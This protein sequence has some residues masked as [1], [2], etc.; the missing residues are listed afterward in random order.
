[1]IYANYAGTS[2]PKPQAVVAAVEAAQLADPRGNADLYRGAHAEVARYFGCDHPERLL[3]APSCTSALAVAIG[4]L[5]WR[6]GD[7]VITSHLEHHAL[8][9]PIQKLAWDHGV[10]HEIAPYSPG[11]PIDLAW[12]A[13][14][15]KQGGVKLIAVTGASN[16]TGELLPV[17]ELSELAHSHGALLL[18]DAAQIAGVV[19]VDVQSLAI[20]LLVF[21][22]HKGMLA[23]HGVGGLWA[24]PHVEFICP[25]ATCEV[26]GVDR[27]S[28]AFP[29]YCDVG[30]V[31]FAALAGLR[32]SIQCLQGA[33]ELGWEKPRRLAERLW[34]ECQDRPHCNVLGGNKDHTAIVSMLIDHIPLEHA[35]QHFLEREIVV[36]AGQHCAP[37][38]LQ[39]LRVPDGCLRISFGPANAP[40]DVDAI[41]S[42][43]DAR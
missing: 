30:S 16:I 31:N 25:T 40:E 10:E 11:E 19:P 20:D 3:I 27:V 43:I 41:L 26:R 15:L 17:A 39:A 14:R 42:A 23:P 37:L 38:G 2:W 5:V 12:V 33:Q 22:G 36:R 13:N 34:Q 32:A 21:A 8:V 4:D 9:R 18:L 1:V 6:P 28:A 7:V 29:G 35:Q 24:A